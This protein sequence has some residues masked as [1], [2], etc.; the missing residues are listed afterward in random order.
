MI[1][2]AGPRQAERPVSSL[3]TPLT[4][5]VGRQHE[6][7]AGATMLRDRQVRLLTLTGAPGTGKTRLALGLCHAVVDNFPDGVW[8]VPLAG[9]ERPDLVVTTIAQHLGIHQVGRRPLIEAFRRVLEGQR[10][11]LV[12]DN[13]QQHSRARL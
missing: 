5:L 4:S 13:S 1:P 12:L 7:S 11:L 2:P 10:L 8:F 3:P 6:L 9:L